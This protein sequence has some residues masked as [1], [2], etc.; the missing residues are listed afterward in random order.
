MNKHESIMYKFALDRRKSLA[1]SQQIADGMIRLIL[2]HTLISNDA[3]PHP[4]LVGEINCVS[5]DDIVAAYNILISKGY[6]QKSGNQFIVKNAIIEETAI[7]DMKSLFIT[8]EKAGYQASFDTIEIKKITITKHHEL[9]KNFIE[10]NEVYFYRRIYYANQFPAFVMDSYLSA[11]KFQIDSHVFN[12]DFIYHYL[13]KE[14][15]IYPA[16]F[17]R[18]LSIDQPHQDILNMLQLIDNKSLIRIENTFYD[19][20]N[21][22]IDFSVLWAAPN[23]VV[24]MD[25]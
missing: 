14:Y 7:R 2:N 24:R 5:L 11:T 20:Y 1:I 21:Q 18:R 8:I 12:N 15:H 6:V 19:Q 17:Y 13:Q 10:D 25:K 16:K 22:F 23:Y 4:D 9:K 3:L